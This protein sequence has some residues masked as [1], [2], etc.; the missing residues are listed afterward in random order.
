[1]FPE[2]L[3]LTHPI[4]THANVILTPHVAGL[5][6]ETATAQTRFSVSQVMDV[7]KGGEPTFPV[8]PEAWQGPASRRPGAKP[9]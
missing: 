6:A 9:G 3:P 5:T 4:H 7:L 2:P 8:N 1:T